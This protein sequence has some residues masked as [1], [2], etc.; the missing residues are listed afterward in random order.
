MGKPEVDA[1]EEIAGQKHGVPTTYTSACRISDERHS[2][3]SVYETERSHWYVISHHTVV[4]NQ[5]EPDMSLPYRG[6]I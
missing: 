4:Q 3:C 6:L 2:L 5:F 1:Y